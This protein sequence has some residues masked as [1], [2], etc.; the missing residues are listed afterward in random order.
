MEPENVRSLARLGK[1]QGCTE[2]LIVAG[3]RPEEKYGAARRWL[4][5]MDFQALQIM[6]H[7]AR[8]LH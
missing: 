4:E 2:A 8:R 7:F 5:G 6:Q 1:K 3:E